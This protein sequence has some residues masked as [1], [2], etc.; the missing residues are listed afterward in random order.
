MR[1]VLFYVEA[2]VLIC[3]F[4]SNMGKQELHIKIL[5]RNRLIRCELFKK[6]CDR[7]LKAQ[8]EI[9]RNDCLGKRVFQP[10]SGVLWKDR[11]EEVP[12]QS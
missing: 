12:A 3:G 6:R 11:V 7:E 10:D 4:S 1:N 2:L 8:A 9:K 5:V